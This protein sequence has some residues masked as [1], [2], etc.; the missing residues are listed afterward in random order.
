MSRHSC[1]NT[2]VNS[3]SLFELALE[4]RTFI[5]IVLYTF[6]DTTGGNGGK[7]KRNERKNVTVNFLYFKSRD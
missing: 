6:M 7:L 1:V 3:T 2:H 5:L 4:K